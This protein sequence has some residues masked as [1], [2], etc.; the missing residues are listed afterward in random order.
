[1]ASITV[2]RAKKG[3]G[4]PGPADR[5]Y[6]W[7]P[8]VDFACGI[9]PLL[10]TAMGPRQHSAGDLDWHRRDCATDLSDRQQRSSSRHGK[11][12]VR[13]LFRHRSGPVAQGARQR[14]HRHGSWA[15]LANSCALP[16]GLS[17]GMAPTRDAFPVR[18]EGN[19]TVACRGMRPPAPTTPALGTVADRPETTPM[20]CGGPSKEEADRPG[21]AVAVAGARSCTAILVYWRAIFRV[22]ACRHQSSLPTCQAA[23]VYATVQASHARDCARTRMSRA[24]GLPA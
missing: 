19:R 18:G 4:P 6:R 1:V 2:N 12:D 23:T 21:I 13:R 20:L 15:L 5:P 16:G 8:A 22:A 3:G 7:R 11:L 14:L 24:R 10:L 9:L 17:V